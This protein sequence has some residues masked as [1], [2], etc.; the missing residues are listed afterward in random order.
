MEVRTEKRKMNELT[1]QTTLT[2]VGAH[3]SNSST[4]LDMVLW[5]KRERGKEMEG[6]RREDG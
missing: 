6:G 4:Q 3:R 5:R 1:F 2:T